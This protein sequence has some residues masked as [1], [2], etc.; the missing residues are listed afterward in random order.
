MAG[1]ATGTRKPLL[2]R[3]DELGRLRDLV[4]AT[5][6][7]RGASVVLEGPAGIGKTSLLDAVHDLATERA[8][9]ALTARGG[10]LER[11][12]AYG[13]VRQLLEPRVMSAGPDE[14]AA[15]LQGAAATAGPLVGI[16]AGGEDHAGGGQLG[17]DRTAAALHGL[18]WLTVN[19]ATETPLALVVDDLHWADSASVRFLAYVAR[20]VGHLPILLVAASR[21][22]VESHAPELI[23]ALGADP[24]VRRLEPAPLSRGAVGALM[25]RELGLPPAP[26]LV[27][28]CHAVTGGNPFLVRSVI[29]A[30][31]ERGL[32]PTAEQAGRLPDVGGPSVAR[33]VARRLSALGP[34]AEALA[35]AVAMLGTDVEPRHAQRLAGLDEHRASEA[36]DA[37]AAAAVLD[38]GRPLDFVHPLV[39]AAAVERIP[40]AERALNH[41]AAARMLDAEGDDP[42]RIAPHLLA[43]DRRADP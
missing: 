25:E 24:T 10:E 35:Q 38:T 29:D 21:P 36:A 7:G 16:P 31:A 14:R 20:R 11:D 26:E 32:E 27:A 3:E 8:L 37:L 41:L 18:Y 17:A 30:L 42:E 40:P 43:C 22:P 2:E 33:S 1:A 4:A 5:A 12:F 34:D 19:L 15:L 9:V 13:V 6:E 23:E 28:D 39:R